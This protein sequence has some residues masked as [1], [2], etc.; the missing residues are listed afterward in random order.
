MCAGYG[1]TGH[2]VPLTNGIGVL[3]A[4]C[5]AIT[6][7]HQGSKILV[8]HVHLLILKASALNCVVKRVTD[9]IRDLPQGIVQNRITLF[10]LIQVRKMCR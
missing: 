10:P 8:W 4:P 7:I 3:A 1:I 2:G 9:E 6:W 5:V